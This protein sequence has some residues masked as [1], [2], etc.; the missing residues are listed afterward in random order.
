MSQTAALDRI[1][2]ALADPTR[3]AIVARLTEGEATV[4]EIAEPFRISLPAVSRHLKVL[5]SAGVIARGRDA[6]R[7]PCRI[8]PE[9]IA[10]VSHWSDHTARA[11]EERLDRLEAHL[12]ANPEAKSASQKG[13][14][15]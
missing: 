10:A 5:E 4:L 11:W 15:T 12:K 1:F 9:A 6:Q 13:P 2:S 14:R 7:R 3:R 8:R